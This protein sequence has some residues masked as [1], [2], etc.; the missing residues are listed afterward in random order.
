MHKHSAIALYS[1]FVVLVLGMVPALSAESGAPLASQ[2]ALE[3]KLLDGHTWQTLSRDHKIAY[4]W[5]IGNL[6]E[7]ERT[8]L[9][10]QQPQ[11][12]ADDRKSFIPYLAYGLRGMSIDQIIRQVDAYYQA[13][14]DQRTQPVL[15]AIFQAIVMPRLKEARASTQNR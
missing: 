4:V 7:L 11:P 2:S 1:L 13:H 6:V 10:S 14:A 9:P 8:N 3:P 12:P 5:G 15:N